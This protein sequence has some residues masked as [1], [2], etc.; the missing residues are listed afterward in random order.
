[1]KNQHIFYYII[2]SFNDKNMI[3][4]YYNPKDT[5]YIFLLHDNKTIKEKQFN[6][7]SRK[8]EEKDVPEIIALEN[9]LNR[10]PDYMFLPSFSGIPKPVCFLEKRRI[11]ER[12]IYY[13]LTGLWKEIKDWCREKGIDCRGIYN[14]TDFDNP[15]KQADKYLCCT[16][17]RDSLEDFKQYIDNWGLNL[18]LRDYQYEAVWKILHYKQSMSQLATRAG[19]TLVAYCI[20]RY[21]LEHGAHNCLMVVPSISLV[22]QGVEDMNEYQEFFTTEAIWAE[23]EYCSGANLTI[24]TFQSLVKRCTKG[25]YNTKNKHYNPQFFD[26]FDVICIDE[27]HKG[28]CE[29]IKQI[30]AQPFIK[31]AK[32]IFGFSGTLPD[33]NTIESYG[34]QSLMGPC[35]QDISTM[36]LVN[37]GYLAKPVIHQ[38]RLKYESDLTDSYIKYGE[39]L[40]SNYVLKDGKKI[41]LP[42]EERD[43]TMIHKKELPI[44][45][46]DARAKVLQ[47]TLTKEQYKDMLVD[48]C[49]A[50]GANLL[51]LEQ[52]IA[53]HSQKKLETIYE[54]LFTNSRSNGIVFAHN[55]SYVDFLQEQIQ[56]RFPGRNVYK[57]K[58][59]TTNKKRLKII[60]E[61]NKNDKDA[62]LVASFGTVATGLTF[63]NI[64][65]AIFAQSFKSAIIN[66]Q[67]IGRGLLLTESKNEFH[68]YDI[69]DIFPTECLKKQGD[70]KTK[71]YR[72][73]KFEYTI[74]HK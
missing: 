42:K 61:M 9:H 40:C 57:I 72:E 54:L 63:K 21:M 36:E 31:N 8:Y 71:L 13:C 7:R 23:G 4:L 29:S 24:G 11:G 22:K 65:Y 1:V 47:K 15:D 53:E 74:E 52:M 64:D 6:K 12:I 14:L 66:N 32:L 73:K 59:S 39:Y 48:M 28:D 3:E 51:V 49:K 43:M 70:S 50:S 58:G 67:A 45:L 19:K 34:C 25:K 20:F 68:L 5:R 27:C 44:V 16:D 10:I 17:F 37:A 41:L 62:I 33:R 46:K 60:E 2:S 26:K 55:E 35:I 30:M 56:A 38:I 69:I 18:D